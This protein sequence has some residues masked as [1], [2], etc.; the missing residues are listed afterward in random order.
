MKKAHLILLI[1]IWVSI[2]TASFVW[3]YSLVKSNNKEVVLNKSQAF[4][5]QIKTARTWNSQHGGVYVPITSTTKPNPYL[6]D[7]LRD[8]ITIDGLKLTKI[9]PAYMTRQISEINKI[10]Y[11]LQFHITSLNPIRPANKADSWETTALK[12]FELGTTEILELVE[13]DSSSHYR[14]M[15]PLI[16]ETTCLQCHSQQGYK[17]GDIRGGISVSFPSEI[18]SKAVNE[19][20]LS[21]G[22]VHILILI[23]GLV[24]LFVYDRMLKKYFSII[25]SKNIELT[26]INATKDKFFSIIAHDLKSPFNS[27]LG[28]TDLLITDYEKIDEEERREIINAI[29]KSSKSS[30]KLLEN[31]LLWA[32]SQRDE[33]KLVKESLNLKTTILEAIEAYIP[34]AEM[35][36]ITYELRV[37]DELNINADKFTV[38]IIIGNL[39]NNAIK[40]TSPKGNVNIDAIQK[41]NYMEIC[42]SDNGVGISPEN[43]SKLFLIEENI[44]TLGTNNEK[45]TGLGLV[46]CKEFIKKHNG[47]I[48]VESE[49]GSGTKIN[50]T[51]PD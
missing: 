37:S 32:I 7:T 51:I 20:L 35:K 13:D 25:E 49:L 39:F 14:Y 40:F 16:T 33:I 2:T 29:D 12:S 36:N 21:L 41:D 26:K 22:V 6:N 4:F 28:F 34:G 45:G 23:F 48:W 42:I 30:F 31:L 3:N 24:G 19:Q 44:S 10:E 5:E 27:I 17:Y 8:I 47:K 15:T 1:I 43:I 38:K 11:D 18:Y 50:F 46:L 9:N